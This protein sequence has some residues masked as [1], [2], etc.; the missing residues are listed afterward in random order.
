MVEQH[1]Q[2]GEYFNTIADAIQHLIVEFTTTNPIRVI[3]TVNNKHYLNK[4]LYTPRGRH[5]FHTILKLKI[6]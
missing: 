2:D 1:L 6:G 4:R 3:A 5:I